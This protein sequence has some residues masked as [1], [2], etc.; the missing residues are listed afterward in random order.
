MKMNKEELTPQLLNEYLSYDPSVGTLTWIKRPSKKVHTGSRAGT[1]L[2]SGYRSINLFG[3]SYQEHHLIWFIYY[4]EWVQ[5]IDHI[6]HNKSDNSI[7]NLRSV[8]HQENSK[9]MKKLSNTITGEQGIYH[10]KRSDRYI[11]TIR[12]KGKV[13]FSKSCTPDKV[14]DLIKEREAKLIELGFHNNHGK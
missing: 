7:D 6:N 11:A 1:H 9:N 5:E 4:G 14:D 8:T 13:V 10:D 3:R 2:K 12:S